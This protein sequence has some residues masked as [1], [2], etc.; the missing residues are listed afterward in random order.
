MIDISIHLNNPD[1]M[2]MAYEADENLPQNEPGTGVYISYDKGESWN[3]Y[4]NML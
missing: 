2:V 4:L 1:I 3:F